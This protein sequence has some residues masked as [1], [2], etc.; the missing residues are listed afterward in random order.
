MGAAYYTKRLAN[1]DRLFGAIAEFDPHD[2]AIQ[3]VGDE[4]GL[5]AHRHGVGPP[6]RDP[7]AGRVR[8]AVGAEPADQVAVRIEHPHAELARVGEEAAAEAV[9]VEPRGLAEADVGR[10]FGAPRRD[11]A[12]ARE[13]PARALDL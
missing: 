4:H 8:V 7:G 3:P 10:A 13:D 1:R 5:V 12:R 11:V 2:P 6:E 9:H